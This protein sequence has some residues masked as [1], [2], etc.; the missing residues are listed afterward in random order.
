MI[1]SASFADIVHELRIGSDGVFVGKTVVEA[2][3]TILAPIYQVIGIDIVG[4]GFTVF[5]NSIR[6]I[7]DD[8]V[9][10]EAIVIPGRIAIV[11]IAAADNNARPVSAVENGVVHEVDVIR[12]MPGMQATI[13]NAIDK[14]VIYV[15][16]CGYIYALNMAARRRSDM[17]DDVADNV[18]VFTAII[19]IRTDTGAT[20]IGCRDLCRDVMNMIVS[21]HG[22][23]AA[24]IDTVKPA[25]TA[26]GTVNV[27]SN[28]VNIISSVIPQNTL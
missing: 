14:V 24:Y 26:I 6:T 20:V 3:V 16:I 17:V 23:G 11:I 10:D 9:C 27:K 1:I 5:Y 8:I 25:G 4:A 19:S 18:V 22:V 15:A 7:E 21:D 12:V 28:D 2:P 13:L